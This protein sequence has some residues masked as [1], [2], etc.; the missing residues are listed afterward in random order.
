MPAIHHPRSTFPDTRAHAHLILE[1]THTGFKPGIPGSGLPLRQALSEP[2]KSFPLCGHWMMLPGAQGCGGTTM[3]PLSGEAI[4]NE[5][6]EVVCD[7]HLLFGQFLGVPPSPSGI[8][9]L[10]WEMPTGR[11]RWHLPVFWRPLVAIIS[12]NNSEPC[13]LPPDQTQRLHW[14]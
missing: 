6:S 10:S 11:S 4:R 7:Q 13:L 12:N 1:I 9:T 14:P 5:A 8:P 3:L 2:T